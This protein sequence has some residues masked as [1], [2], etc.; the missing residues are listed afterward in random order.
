MFMMKKMFFTMTAA[1]TLALPVSAQDLKEGEGTQT[2]ETTGVNRPMNAPGRR[3]PGRTG[4]LDNQQM[5]KRMTEATA[6]R[7]S[8]DEQQTAKLLVLNTKYA[9]V[10]GRNFFAQR[11][12]RPMKASAAVHNDSIKA[13]EVEANSKK[14]V[15]EDKMQ[16]MREERQKERASQLEAYEAELQKL[17]TPEQYDAYQKD[18]AERRKMGQP[19]IKRPDRNGGDNPEGAVTEGAEPDQK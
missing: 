9:G 1:L 7:Y 13:P 14:K 2:Q 6:K 18:K 10:L 11:P 12:Q 17:F 16:Q 15:P 4:K 5:V 8:L 3:M 19:R